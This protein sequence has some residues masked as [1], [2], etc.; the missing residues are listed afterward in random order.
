MFVASC[1]RD[2]GEEM[3]RDCPLCLLRPPVWSHFGLW[4]Q[5]AH[6]CLVSL[7]ERACAM[8]R[9]DDWVQ[10]ISFTWSWLPLAQS[11]ERD[12]WNCRKKGHE[13]MAGLISARA[14]LMRNQRINLG[15]H[16]SEPRWVERSVD[17]LPSCV[18][19]VSYVSYVFLLYSV[20]FCV[21]SIFQDWTSS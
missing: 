10:R 21:A 14:V 7:G 8:L 12:N 4:R 13:G 5:S 6:F 18:S 16:H 3:W 15:C 19:Y 2:G 20:V 1:C 17:A 11:S 9:L